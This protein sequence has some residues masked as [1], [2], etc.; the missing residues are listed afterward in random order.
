MFISFFN[1]NH[2]GSNETKS[3]ESYTYI[4]NQETLTNLKEIQ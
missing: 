1:L 4:S 2:H 3:Q